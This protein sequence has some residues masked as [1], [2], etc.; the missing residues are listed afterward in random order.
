VIFGVNRFKEINDSLGHNAGDDTLRKL[1]SRLKTLPDSIHDIARLGGDEFAFIVKDSK[2]IEKIDDVLEWI[3][4]LVLEPISIGEIN[5]ECS[6]SAGVSIYPLHGNSVDELFKYADIAMYFAKD[7]QQLFSIYKKEND[8]FNIKRLAISND[9]RLAIKNGETALYYQ[10]KIE[11]NSMTIAGVEALIRWKHPKYGFISPEEF[12][13]IAEKTRLI[14]SI[15][16]W[17]IKKAIDDILVLKNKGITIPI[18]INLSPANFLDA[19]FSNTML[20]LLQEKSFN[21]SLIEFEIT[22]SMFL[23][24]PQ[25]AIDKMN[26]LKEMG[27]L[28]AIDDY[29]TGFSSLNMLKNIPASILKLDKSFFESMNDTNNTIVKSTIQLA[30]AL[31]MK[32]VAEGVETMDTML[33]LQELECDYGQGYLFSKPLPCN[34]LVAWIRNW[35][36]N[37]KILEENLTNIA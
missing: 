30:H 26:K 10:P 1:A 37:S 14:K 34:Q 33:L 3:Q 7:N 15:S 6:I 31:N 9:L 24:D 36:Y 22:E 23:H 4:N 29:G 19:E 18:A 21:R 16:T 2:Q 12:I 28:F 32:V 25:N 27:I 8:P 35:D 17:V 5:V 20:N 11:L 13:P